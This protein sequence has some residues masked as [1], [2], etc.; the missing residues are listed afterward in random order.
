MPFV[1]R[2]TVDNAVDE[3]RFLAG[4]VAFPATLQ[5]VTSIG[6]S[7]RLLVAA[8][9]WQNGQRLFDRISG[10]LLPRTPNGDTDAPHSST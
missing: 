3:P 5:H 10:E 1:S 7:Q 8:G 9:Q 4:D 6:N 2:P